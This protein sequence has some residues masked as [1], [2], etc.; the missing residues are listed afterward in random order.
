MPFVETNGISLFYEERGAGDPLILIMGITASGASWE[1]HAIHWQAEFRC[2]LPDNRGIGQTDKPPGPYTS[3]MMADDIVGLMDCLSIPKARIVGCSMGS[4]IAQQ[5][6]LQ[7]PERVKSAVLMCPW[8]R[9]DSYAREVFHHLVNCN[10]RL[11][12]EEFL[13]YIQLLIFSKSSWDDPVFHASMLEDR[14]AAALDPN[15]QPLFALEAQAAA[16]TGHNILNRLA[17]I[18]CPCLVI[19]G[20]NDIFTPVWMAKEI[21]SAMPSCEL[22][23]YENAGHGFHWEH[24]TDFNP[25]VLAWLR[26]H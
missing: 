15:L 7:Y 12:P 16:C 26:S 20:V 8:A 22:H 11:T 17:T 25:R 1:K 19:G 14:N 9:V 21:A 3:V 18:Q 13:A 4:I 2:I 10:A 23:L 5:I 24:L 6:M